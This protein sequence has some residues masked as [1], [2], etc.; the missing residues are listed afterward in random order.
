MKAIGLHTTLDPP[1]WTRALSVAQ[2]AK[3]LGIVILVMARS[4]DLVNAENFRK[5]SSGRV[6]F[7][8]SESEHLETTHK[9]VNSGMACRLLEVAK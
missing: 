1:D 9:V 7:F 3:D 5:L 8:G 2:K 6:A 4:E